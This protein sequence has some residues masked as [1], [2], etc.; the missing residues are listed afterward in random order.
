MTVDGV[1]IFVAHLIVVNPTVSV[2]GYKLTQA[3]ATQALSVAISVN[4]AG[5]TFN[6]YLVGNELDD[7]ALA[8]FQ[9]TNVSNLAWDAESAH[10]SG[11]L[12]SPP[13]SMRIV[14]DGTTI[15][16]LSIV[17]PNGGDDQVDQD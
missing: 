6:A 2:T 17:V 9:G 3:G 16:T 12:T 7:L 5:D 14:A 4:A 8:N 10:L 1:D 11:N 13:S 15:G